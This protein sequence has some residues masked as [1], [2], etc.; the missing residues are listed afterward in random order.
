MNFGNLNEPPIDSIIRLLAQAA[1]I[2]QEKRMRLRVS[3]AIIS[4]SLVAL[5]EAEHIRAKVDRLTG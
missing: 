2:A 5:D 3:Q 4:A 1:S